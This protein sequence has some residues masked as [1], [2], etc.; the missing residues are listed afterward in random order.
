MHSVAAKPCK[1]K[2]F[3]SDETYR[4]GGLAVSELERQNA[5]ADQ[6]RPVDPLI[7]LSNYSLDTH[8]YGTLCGPVP[9][10]ACPVLLTGKDDQ[11]SIPRAVPHRRV[12]NSHVLAVGL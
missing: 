10:A 5:H 2:G 9:R 8:K 4:Q 6:V 1:I 3:I 7:G 11:G 12:I